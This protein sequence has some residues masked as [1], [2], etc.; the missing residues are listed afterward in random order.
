MLNS[1]R[2]LLKKKVVFNNLS[3]NT[4]ISKV[5]GTDRGKPIDRYYIEKF[6][7]LNKKL[8]RGDVIEIADP[9]YIKMF[10]QDIKKVHILNAIPNKTATIV[11]DLTDVDKLPIGIADCFLCTQTYN[12]IYDT[13]L[14]IEGS[15]RLLKNNGVLIATVAG[16]SQISRYDADKWGDFWRF[17]D[18]S[19]KRI[20]IEVF[21][22]DNVEV[23]VYGNVL[24]A[25]ALLQ[26]ISVEDLPEYRLLDE[27]DIDYQVIIGVIAKKR[28]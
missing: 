19:I 2:K 5:F 23:I 3:T 15:Y 13:K 16:I 6:L 28:V 9:H 21:G 1:I 12:F 10:G 11:G 20:F 25:I 17:T 27:T 26:G 22:K 8:I 7:L 18:N 4:P 24:A 14:A